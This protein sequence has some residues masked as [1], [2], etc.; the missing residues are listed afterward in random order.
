MKIEDTLDAFVDGMTVDPH[1]LDAALASAEGRA[2]L[3]DT[4]ALRGLMR[5]EPIETAAPKRQSSWSLLGLARAAVIA[6]AFAGL[7]Y[8]AGTRTEAPGRV[9][10]PTNAAENVAPPEPTRVIELTPGVNWHESKG[11]D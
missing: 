1:A 5:D 4:L 2:Y 3:L 8:V 7:G 10:I 6:L 9:E 11:G